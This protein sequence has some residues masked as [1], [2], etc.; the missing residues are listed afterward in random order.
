MK[1]CFTYGTDALLLPA[2]VVQH[3]D[4]ASKRDIKVLL[5]LAAEPLARIDLAAACRAVA[6]SLSLAEQEVDAAL[7]FWRGTGVID[8]LEEEAS[9]VPVVKEAPVTREE[10]AVTPRMMVEHGIPSYSSTELSGL[11]ERRRDLA[12]LVDECQRVFGKIFNTREVSLI[13][14]MI[15][16]LGFEGDYILLLLSHCV[17]MEKKSLRYV[18]KMAI[19]LYDEG[20]TDSHVLEERLQ[21]IEL[22]ASSVGKIRAMFGIAS[23]ALTAKEK[24]MVE[25]WVCTMQYSD[26]VIRLAYE[27]TVNAINKASITYA[28]SILERW[29][30]AG[31]RTIEDV[32]RALSEYKR[33]KKGDSFDVDDFFEA[34]LKRTYGE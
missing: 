29:Y 1:L 5:S 25:N 17:R 13:A 22:M 32:E 33:K 3:V 7:S 2:K 12:A 11:L 10:P 27:T 8:V 14:G 28:N 16:Y 26:A 4:K 19:S 21:R 20:V 30:A 15:D 6:Q 18:E 24:G 34:A 31:Y 23:R 9:A